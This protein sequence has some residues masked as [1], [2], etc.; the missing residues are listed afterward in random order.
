MEKIKIKSRSK[1]DL[2]EWSYE[3]AQKISKST[4]PE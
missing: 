3:A 2:N 4:S 1:S